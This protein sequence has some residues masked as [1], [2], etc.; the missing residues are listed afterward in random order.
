MSSQ[1]RPRVGSGAGATRGRSRGGV[2]GGLIGLAFG[3]LWLLVGSTAAGSAGTAFLIGGSAVFLQAAWRTITREQPDEGRFN[4]VYYVAAVVAE[5]VAVAASQS[6]LSAHQ[7]GDLLFPV[8]GIVVGLHFIGLWLASRR[9]AFLCLSGAMVA[10][11]L[12]ALLLPLS[13]PARTM[14]SGFGSSFSLL[15]AVVA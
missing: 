3:W 11:N 7:R 10:I 5:I 1:V 13:A 2:I 14:L 8:V 6:W 4:A 15:V 12:L 9:E